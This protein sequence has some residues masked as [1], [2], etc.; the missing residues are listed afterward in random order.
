LLTSGL[1]AVLGLQAAKAGNNS[2]LIRYLSATFVLGSAF[3]VIK[4]GEWYGYLTSGTFTPWGGTLP[5]STYFLTVGLH[6]AH[7]TAGL[8]VMAYL[9]NKARKGGFSKTN[10]TGVENFAMYWAFVDLVWVF[11]FP[12]FYLL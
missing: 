7:V 3:M 5:E 9:I 8:V 2:A 4:A 11:V 12:L 6:G 10:F 1:T